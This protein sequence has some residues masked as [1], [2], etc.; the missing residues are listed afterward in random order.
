VLRCILRH[1][2]LPVSRPH[3]SGFARLEFEA[4]YFVIRF[5]TFYGI[6]KIVS[7]KTTTMNTTCRSAAGLFLPAQLKNNKFNCLI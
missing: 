1:C 2:G 7:S 5:P 4:F 6:I 3:F